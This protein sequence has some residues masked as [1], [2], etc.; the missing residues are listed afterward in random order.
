MKSNSKQVTRDEMQKWHALTDTFQ[1]A[2]IGLLFGM[3]F[4]LELVSKETARVIVWYIAA[5]ILIFATITL[6]V[7]TISAKKTS[8]YFKSDYERIKAKYEL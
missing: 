8:A 4:I 2:S 5:F 1:F 3:I 7:S 6:A